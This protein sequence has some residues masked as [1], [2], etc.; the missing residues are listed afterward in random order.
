MR[1]LLA[2]L[3][4]WSGCLTGVFAQQDADNR[5]LS[6][7]AQIQEANGLLN[8]GRSPEALTAYVTVQGQ[9]LDFQ[10]TYPNWDT[11]IVSYRLGDLA[12]KIARLRAQLPPPATAPV[13]PASPPIALAPPPS[14][15][16]NYAGTQDANAPLWQQQVQALKDDNARLQAKLQ[17][18]LSFQ[19]PAADADALAKANSQIRELMK[20]NALLEIG[21]RPPEP[22]PSHAEYSAFARAIQG[23]RKKACRPAD[24]DRQT[25]GPK[26]FA[27]SGLGPCHKIQN[28]DLM[29]RRARGRPAVAITIGGH[30]KPS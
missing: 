15:A 23:I 2:A 29:T 1:S 11:D 16:G 10:H 24:L 27:P 21:H 14:Q 8:N 13:I 17:E 12:E 19:P 9:L 20:E 18:A 6:I 3:L 5:Y 26:S 25:Q 28:E 7:Y 4:F 30:A 22:G